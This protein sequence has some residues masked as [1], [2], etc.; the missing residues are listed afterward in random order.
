MSERGPIHATI[1]EPDECGG[2]DGGIAS[3][4]VSFVNNEKN[5]EW[6]AIVFLKDAC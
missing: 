2:R 3:G 5:C 6:Y 4:H 1:W